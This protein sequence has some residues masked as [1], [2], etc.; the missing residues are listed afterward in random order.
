MMKLYPALC[1]QIGSWNNYTI[2]MSAR[3][4]SESVK[5]ASEIYEDRTLDQ[6]TRRIMNDGPAKKRLQNI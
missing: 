3:E 1:T 4:L 6:A 2:K 5:Y